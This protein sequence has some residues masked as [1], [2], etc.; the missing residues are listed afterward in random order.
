MT[1]KRNKNLVVVLIIIALCI[2]VL[3][4]FKPFNRGNLGV[5]SGHDSTDVDTGKVIPRKDLIINIASPVEIASL[6]K[7]LDVNFSKDYLASTNDISKYVTS[8]K[9]AIVLGVYMADLGYLNMYQRSTNMMSYLTAINTLADNLSL[10]QFFQFDVLKDLAL[11]SQNFDSLVLISVRNF[12]DMDRFLISQGREKISAYMI[13]GGWA[14]GLYI[15]TRVVDENPIP[16]LVEKV[17][18]QKIVLENL[19]E[20]LEYFSQDK[21]MSDLIEKLR[22]LKDT[23]NEV[24]IKVVEGDCVQKEING[25]LVV[26]QTETSIVD[27]SDSTINKII[28]TT[29]DI[30]N[31]LL[32]Y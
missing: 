21:T 27:M 16:D 29:S 6:L 28:Q 24:V 11:N 17:G 30:R 19:L 12:N 10:N 25:N 8:D 1:K 32:A 14:E 31:S 20:L 13:A 15:M 4:V 5:I 7:S 26:E 23:Y 2:I 3:F 18:D 9:Q 22:P